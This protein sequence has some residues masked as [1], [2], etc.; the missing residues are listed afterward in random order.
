MGYDAHRDD[1]LTAMG[2]TSG[3]YAVLVA[4]LLDVVPEAKVIA[5]L[6]GGYDLDAVRRGV[7]ATLTAF[8]G[9]PVLPERQSSGGRGRDVVDE[10]VQMHRGVLG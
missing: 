5:L 1:P 9:S 10:V 8:E 2:L 4:A 7:H 6:E 3:D